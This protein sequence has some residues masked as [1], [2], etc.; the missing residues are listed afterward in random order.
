MSPN[1]RAIL[2]G[3]L[4]ATAI[5][6]LWSM[7]RSQFRWFWIQIRHVWRTNVGAW[8]ARR[9]YVSGFLVRRVRLHRIAR[10]DE[11]SRGVMVTRRDINIGW[12][13]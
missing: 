13:S 9:R 10:P 12:W 3:F 1:D 8:F 2:G 4:F 11:H 7:D 6:F 5:A